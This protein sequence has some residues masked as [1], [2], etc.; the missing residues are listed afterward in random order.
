MQMLYMPRSVKFGTYAEG[1]AG[2]G[3]N[4][5]HD[6]AVLLYHGPGLCRLG[7]RV[8]SASERNTRQQASNAIDTQQARQRHYIM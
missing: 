8:T 7:S 1:G 5:K 2:W 4:S 6:A 3:H